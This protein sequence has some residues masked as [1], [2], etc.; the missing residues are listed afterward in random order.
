MP[1]EILD[2]LISMHVASLHYLDELLTQNLNVLILKYEEFAQDFD[3]L[4]KVLEHHFSITID[5]RDKRL[6]KQA[7]NKENV[8]KNIT[9]FDSFCQYDPYSLFHGFHIDQ[10]EIPKDLSEFLRSEIQSKITN[11]SDIFS[12]W[13]Y[14]VNNL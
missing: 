12:K 11:Y 1:L 9:Q 3:F 14:D 13:G 10:D 7:L 2:T 4:F 6:L 5:S 8:N